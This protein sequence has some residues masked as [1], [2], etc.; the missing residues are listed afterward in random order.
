MCSWLIVHLGSSFG[1]CYFG[2][3]LE[4]LVHTFPPSLITWSKLGLRT[5]VP[6]IVRRLAS[7]IRKSSGV[8]KVVTSVLVQEQD[9][10]LV[11]KQDMVPV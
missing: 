3:P 1:S 2:A 9:I 11:P 6:T 7:R 8:P 10:V 4:N 5:I